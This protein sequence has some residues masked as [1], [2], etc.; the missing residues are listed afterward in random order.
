[1]DSNPD[2]V[3]PKII[4]LIFAVSPLH[5]R[6]G[7]HGVRK[8]RDEISTHSTRKTFFLFFQYIISTN[9]V[10]SN[11]TVCQTSNDFIISGRHSIMHCKFTNAKIKDYKLH[12][13]V[14]NDNWTYWDTYQ[15]WW[16][17]Q[18]NTCKS[19]KHDKTTHVLTDLISSTTREGIYIYYNAWM[20]GLISDF[21]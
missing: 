4:K 11:R 6:T 14:W 12:N 18:L 1:V 5:T 2:R 9:M 3:K 21:F 15:Y 16:K 19:L 13:K 8:M 20:A 7:W 17:R 10:A